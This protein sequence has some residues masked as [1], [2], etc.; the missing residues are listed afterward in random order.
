MR[1][2]WHAIKIQIEWAWLGVEHSTTH[3]TARATSL[4]K[5]H[6]SQFS[7]FIKKQLLCPGKQQGEGLM[8]IE[9]NNPSWFGSTNH[10]CPPP[11]AVSGLQTVQERGCPNLGMG[12]KPTVLLCTMLFILESSHTRYNFVITQF[13]MGR[14]SFAQALTCFM[15]HLHKL[16]HQLA[17]WT[18]WEHTVEGDYTA[19]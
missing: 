4:H 2:G 7:S 6:F 14:T 12:L 10:F 8:A 3:Y 19:T 1:N 16:S 18:L 5:I 17:L 13:C 11:C 9:P 15:A